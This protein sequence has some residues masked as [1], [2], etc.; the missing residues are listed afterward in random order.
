MQYDI[1]KSLWLFSGSR[2]PK[3]ADAVRVKK[4]KSKNIIVFYQN[5]KNT[6]ILYNY[7]SIFNV[8]IK[9]VYM[10]IMKMR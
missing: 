9:R 4:E 1:E 6:K 2:R 10:M 7:Y 5:N 3:R 8:Q